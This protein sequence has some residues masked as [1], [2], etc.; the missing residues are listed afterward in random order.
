MSPSPSLG[1]RAGV[2]AAALAASLAVVELGLRL[3]GVVPD[4]LP[5]APLGR[6]DAEALVAWQ[7]RAGKPGEFLAELEHDPDLGWVP[8]G[9]LTDFAAPGYPPLST[10]SAGMRGR[11]EFELAPEP[12][13]VRIALIGDS[14]TFGT[15]QP[16]AR[17]WA[18]RLPEA[19]GQLGAAQP[20]EVLNFGV[21]GYGTDQALLRLER[22]VLPYRPDIVVWGIFETNPQR[23][24]RL[25]SFYAK[26]RFAL[27]GG[28]LETAG[29]P[30]PTPEDLRAR[31]AFNPPSPS[32]LL[33]FLR[34]SRVQELD[35]GSPPLVELHRAILR[36]ASAICEDAGAELMV[37]P[38]PTLRFAELDAPAH[39]LAGR[40]L[41][42]ELPFEQVDLRAHF[43]AAS[44]GPGP[45]IY[46]PGRHFSPEGHWLLAN[47]VA[48]ELYRSGWLTADR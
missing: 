19:L 47:A 35:A 30:V 27:G 32:R 17:I 41:A 23:S 12:D 6:L 7:E 37:L 8:R 40:A 21:P 18:T 28:S 48:A 38:I 16:D 34:A 46:I 43:R 3:G 24:R 42:E 45:P 4:P 9:G 39:E 5:R 33:Q 36:R 31:A 15:H 13:V 20:V 11:A 10:N 1:R 22:D 2:A 44:A 29:L 14:F 26:P 25:F